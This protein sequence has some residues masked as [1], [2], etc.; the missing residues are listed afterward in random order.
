MSFLDGVM[1]IGITD[2]SGLTRVFEHDVAAA[3]AAGGPAMDL[4]ATLD[5]DAALTVEAEAI[6][7][8][9]LAVGDFGFSTRLSFT[10]IAGVLPAFTHA[11]VA[12][13]GAALLRSPVVEVRPEELDVT[14][15]GD[16][17]PGTTLTVT[18]G[19]GRTPTDGD[20]VLRGAARNE[21]LYG[22]DGA[23][24]LIGLGG[25]DDLY[26]GDG[27]DRLSGGAGADELVGER[28]ADVLLGRA[29]HDMLFGGL[30]ADRMLGHGG[31]DTLQ[32]D[33]GRDRLFGGGGDDYLRSVDGGRLFGGSGEDRL[34]SE[35]GWT[36]MQ[37]GDGDDSLAIGGL[38]NI[39][40]YQDIAGRFAG[41]D[42]ADAFVLQAGLPYA[43]GR[44]GI[45]L[46]DFDRAEGDRID[47]SSID[48]VAVSRGR[49]EGFDWLG[50][51]AFTGTAGEARH[52]RRNDALLLDDDGDGRAEVAIR[53]PE[54][55][56]LWETDLIL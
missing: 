16:H 29:D 49:S 6:V 2:A 9:T 31:D 17:D 7:I 19:F 34:A 27:A 10:D 44:A 8:E 52:D 15:F 39:P 1:T 53:L 3:Q 21:T 25:A 56:K 28:G 48:A 18:L 47:L 54:G 45:A 50:R 33:E 41:G 22:L 13:D 11:E 26:G 36:L 46:T 40:L 38:Y 12:V 14:L 32:G 35:T 20:D 37:G 51:A 4:S 42:G 43:I 23:D 5:L 24:V 55:A 30:G